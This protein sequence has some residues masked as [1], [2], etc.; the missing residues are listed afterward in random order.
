MEEAEG[1]NRNEVS[2][3]STVTAD[4]ENAVVYE[5]TDK[6]SVKR[7]HVKTVSSVCN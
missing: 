6:T 1:V 5:A 7:Y 2:E 4:E 3:G